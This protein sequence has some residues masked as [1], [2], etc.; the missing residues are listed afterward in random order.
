MAAHTAVSAGGSAPQSV[1]CLTKSLV[2]WS[3]GRRKTGSMLSIQRIFGRGRGRRSGAR[4]EV[5]KPCAGELSNGGRDS[6]ASETPEYSKEL[7]GF[8]GEWH[9]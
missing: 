4:Y 2:V 9:I 7:K 5:D 6:T 1:G 3:G 8:D